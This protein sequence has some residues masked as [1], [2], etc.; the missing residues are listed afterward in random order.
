MDELE[1]EIEQAKLSLNAAGGE[2]PP[3][4]PGRQATI[5]AL[6][7][8][9]SSDGLCKTC[10]CV[11]F[12]HFCSDI[13]TI[14]CMILLSPVSLWILKEPLT[15]MRDVQR[16]NGNC[17]STGHRL[18][19][20]WTE[21]EE[22]LEKGSHKRS[23]TK[24]QETEEPSMI[25]K[26]TKSGV[27]DA[28][29]PDDETPAPMAP[30]YHPSHA[31]H[32]P[33]IPVHI[34]PSLHSHTHHASFS[35]QFI[36]FSTTNLVRTPDPF[37]TLLHP[38]TFSLSIPHTHIFLLHPIITINHCL[39]TLHNSFHWGQAWCVLIAWVTN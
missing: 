20:S 10:C 29:R 37:L 9:L 21:W 5:E 32:H 23:S 27:M 13:I 22:T 30:P 28:A 19:R 34:F 35:H 39:V 14:M 7:L 24:R 33:R 8:S 18:W 38:A 36:L 6:S 12:S 16:V 4:S 3:P 1:K 31:N 2:L 25:V 26:S 17:F 11:S 15:L